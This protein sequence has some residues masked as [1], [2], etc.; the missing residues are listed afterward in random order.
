VTSFGP[1][2]RSLEE[3]VLEATTTSSDRV[4]EP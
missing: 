4:D 3:V 2:H 1:Q